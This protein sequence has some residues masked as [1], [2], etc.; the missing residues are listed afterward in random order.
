MSRAI[1][2]LLLFP[3]REHSFTYPYV[4]VD[5][6]DPDVGTFRVHHRDRAVTRASALEAVERTSVAT[7]FSLITEYN[8]E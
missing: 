5:E 6:P 3:T 7:Q 4:V 8:V 1:R 2:E